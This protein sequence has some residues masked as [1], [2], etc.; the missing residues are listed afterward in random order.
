MDP[1]SNSEPL[2]PPSQREARRGDNVGVGC[3]FG[4]LCQIVFIA[5]GVFAA[6]P[7]RTNGTLIWALASWGLTQWLV[8][9]PLIWY[10]SA[11]GYP[12]RVKGLI[13][14]GCIGVLLSSGC[15]AMFFRV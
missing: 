6:I 11:N 9:G 5:I 7:L 10:H 12:R 14:A 13:L 4:L 1:D 2:P 15:A 8:I 3:L